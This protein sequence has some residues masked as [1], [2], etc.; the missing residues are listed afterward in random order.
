MFYKGRSCTGIVV[1]FLLYSTAL[2]Q[3]SAAPKTDDAPIMSAGCVRAGVESGCLILKSFKD[4]TTYSLHFPK[5]RPDP[6]TAISFEGKGGG[7]D[8][9]MQGIVVNVTKWMPLK[10]KCPSAEK[11]SGKEDHR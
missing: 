11:T 8:T 5:E 6:D 1:L 9:C 2:A 7:V 3:Q 10:M 4:K